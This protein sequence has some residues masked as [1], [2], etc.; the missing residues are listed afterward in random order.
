MHAVLCWE[1]FQAHWLSLRCS[2]RG[3]MGKVRKSLLQRQALQ[4]MCEL[5]VADG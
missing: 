2:V 5:I 1:I 4:V 3:I